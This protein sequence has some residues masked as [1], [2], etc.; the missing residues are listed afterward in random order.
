LHSRLA[1]NIN[2]RPYN[3]QFKSVTEKKVKLETKDLVGALNEQITLRL[4]G[5][6]LHGGASHRAHHTSNAS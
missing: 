4:A 3:K 2:L 5:N 1:F 6:K